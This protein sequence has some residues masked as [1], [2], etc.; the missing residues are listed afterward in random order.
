[1]SSGDPT[2]AGGRGTY[3]LDQT[4]A[5]TIPVKARVVRIV[6]GMSAHLGNLK[7][8]GSPLSD[9][10]AESVPYFGSDE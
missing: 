6:T 10:P 3:E 7:P 4:M 9:L 8:V 5:T 2:T 1:M